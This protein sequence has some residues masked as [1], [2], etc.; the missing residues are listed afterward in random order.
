MHKHRSRTRDLMFWIML[1]IGVVGAIGLVV[2][3]YTI[4]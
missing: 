3:L 1:A 2:T 4:R